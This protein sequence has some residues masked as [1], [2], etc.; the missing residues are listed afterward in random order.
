MC[1]PLHL[2]PPP[3]SGPLGCWLQKPGPWL[4][5]LM[6]PGWQGGVHFPGSPLSP[7]HTGAGCRGGTLLKQRLHVSQLIVG[8][9]F[10]GLS[11]ALLGKKSNLCKRQEGAGRPLLLQGASTLGGLRGGKYVEVWGREDTEAQGLMGFFESPPVWTERDPFP[12]GRVQICFCV[13]FWAL[14]G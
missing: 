7:H 10:A 3:R 6:L 8:G 2:L 13:V 1:G 12:W 5:V 14:C 9:Q 11:D 4:V